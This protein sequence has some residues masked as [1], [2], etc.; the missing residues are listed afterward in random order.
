MSAGTFVGDLLIESPSL[1]ELAAGR[2]SELVF[3]GEL[4]PDDRLVE[5]HL[6]ERLGVSRAPVREGLRILEGTGLVVR[7]PRAGV[8][9]AG[10]SQNDVFEILTFREGLERM[11]VEHLYRFTDDLKSVDTARLDRALER[12]TQEFECGEDEYGRIQASY[13]FHTELVRLGGNAR[14]VASYMQITMQ[15]K[16]C[17]SLNLRTLEA[18]ETPAE[19]VARHRDLRSAIL[20][21]DL[22]AALRAID[23]HGH[24]S[25]AREFLEDLP[26][27]TE[28]SARWLAGRTQAEPLPITGDRRLH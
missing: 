6:C 8:R 14:I 2:I 21:G 11:A 18:E 27:G 9:V 4:G 23:E 17:M 28:H 1:A 22:T 5:E 7:R 26:G 13:Q 25:F 19:N 16:L 12:L 20:S 10:L 3:R 15:V 24:D